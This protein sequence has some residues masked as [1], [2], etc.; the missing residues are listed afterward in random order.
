[1]A[2][3]S[4]YNAVCSIKIIPVD[5][6]S[7]SEIPLG[8]GTDFP[9]VT[10]V[11]VQRVFQRTGQIT[12][13]IEAPFFEG[14]EMLNGELFIT[15][16][17]VEVTMS[18]PDDDKANFS[19]GGCILKGGIGLSMT[20]NGLSGTVS[21]SGMTIT[22]QQVKPLALSGDPSTRTFDWLESVALE[23]GYRGL[24]VSERVKNE[25]GLIEVQSYESKELIQYIEDFCA[26][27]GFIWFERYETDGGL[28][29]IIITDDEELDGPKVTRVFVMRDSFID[30]GYLS[31]YDFIRSAG[32]EKAKAYPIISFSPELTQGFFANKETVK[33]KQVGIVADGQREDKSED[34]STVRT[35]K[36]G[37]KTKDQNAGGEDAKAGNS[38]TIKKVDESTAGMT[39]S[40]LYP[41]GKSRDADTKRL[42]RMTARRMVSYNASL[43]TFGI[44]DLEPG[45]RVA[46][47]GLGQLFD[48][49][50]TVKEITQTWTAG[51]I[52]TSLGIFGRS[53]G[54]KE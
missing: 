28:N 46:L 22:A 16:N 19:V 4:H 43:N 25:I 35:V 20:P 51:K 5:G 13:S 23:A 36:R 11:E 10:S 24:V 34:E 38:V 53:N 8:V 29:S 47:V 48:G 39:V 3:S 45:E 1:M 17:R 42:S 41:E 14:R 37:V 54:V 27:N 49:I 7:E 50:F 30:T 18:Y 40:P 52:E 9:F 6:S 32:A 12:I 26:M 33:V 44:P 15:G 21:V 2:G 31:E